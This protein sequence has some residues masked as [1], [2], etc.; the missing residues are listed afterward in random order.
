MTPMTR[1]I[2]KIEKT[3]KGAR[4]EF[5]AYMKMTVMGVIGVMRCHGV[6]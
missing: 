4:V 1:Y 3:A 5:P 2:Y 6:E